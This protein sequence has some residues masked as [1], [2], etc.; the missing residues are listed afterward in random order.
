[1]TIRALHYE[2]NRC[3]KWYRYARLWLATANVDREPTG[4]ALAAC[5]HWRNELL[6]TMLQLRIALAARP[7]RSTTK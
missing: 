7:P 5:K 6:N 3:R 4:P 2:L 1:M